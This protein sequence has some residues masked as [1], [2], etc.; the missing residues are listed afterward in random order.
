MQYRLLEKTELW[1]KPVRLSGVDLGA[2]A[3]A[4]AEALGLGPDEIMVTDAMGDTLTL[5]ILVPTL[6]AERIIGRKQVLLA[7]LG[8]V[9]GLGLTGETD[10]HSDGILGLIGLDE[11]M[12]EEVLRK[13]RA[14]AGSIASHIQMRATIFSTGH[15]VLTGQIQDTNSPFLEEALRGEGYE[16]LVG[17]VLDDDPRRIAR[18]FRE[19]AGDGF[20]LLI[21]TGGI[22]AEGKDKT[23]EALESVDPQA[24]MPYILKFRKG[25]GRHYRD[26]VRIGVGYYDP[27]LIVCLPG[28]HD[29][30][31]LAWPVLKRGIQERWS[32]E[33]FAE[34]LAS[35]LRRKFLL[36]TKSDGQIIHRVDWEK[37]HGIK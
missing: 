9:R 28:P 34:A 12:G 21:T 20:G 25:E 29:E 11:R 2:C 30:V 24:R 15:E 36:K 14:I 19:A 18:A 1:V 5:D 10:I 8:K 6:P 23:L 17:P 35:G 26:G 31:R 3:E 7:A 13:T 37:T 32:K 16:V 4:A 33:I 22:G 27:T